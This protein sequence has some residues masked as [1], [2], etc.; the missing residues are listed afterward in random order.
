MLF[1]GAAQSGS[2]AV[3]NN[4]RKSVS[5]HLEPRQLVRTT[6]VMMKT[7][8]PDKRTYVA[9]D[10]SVKQLNMELNILSDAGAT[11][12]NMDPSELYDEDF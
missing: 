1:P 5:L 6:I 8:V 4:L 7:Q 12:G 11:L 2:L 9:P 10:M 3:C